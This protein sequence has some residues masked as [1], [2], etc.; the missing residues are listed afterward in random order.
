M[1]NAD[2]HLAD[3]TGTEDIAQMETAKNV[4]E[5]LNEH[6][7]NHLWA[8][9]WQGGV[10]VVKN[11]AISSF[12]GFVL[13]PDKLATWSEMKRAAVLAG[14]ELLERA[15]MARGAWAGQFAQVLEGSDPR[16]FRGD[17]T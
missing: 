5:A 11:L 16:F 6:Y 7:P 9:S 17:N 1:S 15:K 13:H 14:G 4:G 12:Y 10:I 8:V 3:L 2:M